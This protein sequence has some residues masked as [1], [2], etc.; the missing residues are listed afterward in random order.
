MTTYAAIFR[1]VYELYARSSAAWAARGRR[2]VLL[3]VRDDIAGRLVV[4]EVALCPR[5][6]APAPSA[7]ASDRSL[8]H[9]G[10]WRRRSPQPGDQ[11]QD[12]GEHLRDTATS[13]IWK[14]T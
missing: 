11:R 6:D 5:R 12:V 4:P 7:V 14:V 13:A 9:V 8:R 3:T 10:G 2:G 1:K